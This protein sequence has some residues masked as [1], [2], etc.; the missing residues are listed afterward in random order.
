MARSINID[1]GSTPHVNANNIGPSR[2]MAFG[3]YTGGRLWIQDESGDSSCTLRGI[4][5]TG[6]FHAIYEE[7]LG[8]D[9]NRVHYTEPFKGRRKEDLGLVTGHKR[10]S[11]I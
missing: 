7:W 10:K 8:F 3:R 4:T 2:I 6:R 5:Y 11:S 9:G 1:V